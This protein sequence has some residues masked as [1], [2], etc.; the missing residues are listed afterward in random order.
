MIVAFAISIAGFVWYTFHFNQDEKN[1][2]ARKN[3]EYFD[4]NYSVTYANG[5]TAKTWI[6]RNG[7]V[8]TTDKGYYFFWS[9]NGY[10]QV[11]IANTFIEEIK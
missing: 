7:K 3:I 8:T 4:S 5:P 2:L 10:V 11:P 1:K 6:I 9:V